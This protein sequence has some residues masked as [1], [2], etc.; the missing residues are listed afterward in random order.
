MYRTR[1]RL[2]KCDSW[3]HLNIRLGG[4]PKIRLA[5]RE[6]RRLEALGEEFF[7]VLIGDARQD[8]TVLPLC[9]I[10]GCSDFMTDSKLQRIDDSQ[11]LIKA[12]AGAGGVGQAELDL[13]ITADDEDG[14]NGHGHALRVGGGVGRNHAVQAGNVPRG[15]RDDREA[16]VGGHRD[17]AEGG[18]VGQPLGVRLVVVARQRETLDV[19]LVELREQLRD[20]RE[21]GGAHRREIGRVRE[22][23]GPLARD[24]GM[25][26][27]R[28]VRGL[29]L[30][31]WGL[32]AEEERHGVGRVGGGG[33]D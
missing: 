9:P 19:A 31:V 22:E 17:R 23:H 26:V 2:T 24:V 15:V 3:S 5:R 27:D 13:L 12:P 10:D 16:R 11:D 7:G 29:G 6:V 21:L 8:D 33:V 20:A 28:A 32:V 25:E 18:D 30:E 14:S 4:H 1:P